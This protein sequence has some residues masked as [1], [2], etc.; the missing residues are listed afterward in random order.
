MTTTDASGPIAVGLA[1]ANACDTPSHQECPEFLRCCVQ[2]AV[3]AALAPHGPSWSE[4]EGWLTAHRQEYADGEALPRSEG[5][6]ALDDAL[7]DLREHMHTGTPLGRPV[8]RTE[9][10]TR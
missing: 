10:D 4:V 1:A 5:Y 9:E 6:E 8:Q 3:E 2:A 7:D